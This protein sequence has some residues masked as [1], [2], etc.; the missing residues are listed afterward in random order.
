MIQL[1]LLPGEGRGEGL[2][3]KKPDAALRLFKAEKRK[4]DFIIARYALAQPSP[5]ARGQFSS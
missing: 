3:G 4:Y 1:P 5:K 2:A